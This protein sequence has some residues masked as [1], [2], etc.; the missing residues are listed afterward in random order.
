MPSKPKTPTKAPAVST[1]G[2][3]CK[4]CGG[5]DIQY[6]AT[7]E[8][9]GDL[10]AAPDIHM[11]VSEATCSSCGPIDA[12]VLDGKDYDDSDALREVLSG[13]NLSEMS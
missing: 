12:L 7:V 4:K 8:V 1:S 10:N 6:S 9:S 13:L 11:P 5:R 3:S 2:W